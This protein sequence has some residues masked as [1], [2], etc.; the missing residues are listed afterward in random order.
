M[1]SEIFWGNP[2]KTIIQI[3]LNEGWDWLD[4][5]HIAPTYLKM[6][7]SVDH[8]VHLI[9]NVVYIHIPRNTMKNLHLLMRMTHPR[10][11]KTVV[12]GHI[13]LVRPVLMVAGEIPGLHHYMQHY[14]FAE[15]L[16]EAYELLG[17]NSPPDFHMSMTTHSHQHHY[18]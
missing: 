15:T 9:F 10:E 7:E 6:M 13:P 14:M 8:R 12:V 4:L 16:S 17:D 18:Q 2:E 1:N 3:N 11:D 5:H